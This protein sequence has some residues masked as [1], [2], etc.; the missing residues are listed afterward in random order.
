MK[1]GIYINPENGLLIT[2][3]KELETLIENRVEELKSEITF[4]LW[5]DENYFISE[6]FG[7]NEEEKREVTE[8]YQ[9]YLREEALSRIKKELI[10]H[11]ITLDEREIDLEH[12]F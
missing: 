12:Y 8:G 3:S 4:D 2:T 10:P 7:M 1:R 6:V 11:T 5:L 9:L